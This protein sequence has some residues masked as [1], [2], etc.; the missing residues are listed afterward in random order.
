ML[1]K[2]ISFT[3]HCLRL[4]MTPRNIVAICVTCGEPTSENKVVPGGW[5]WGY[6]ERTRALED[7]LTNSGVGQLLDFS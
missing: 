6:K 3:G 5:Q 2:R 4:T 7:K 1:G